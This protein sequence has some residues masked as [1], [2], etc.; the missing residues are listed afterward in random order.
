LNLNLILISLLTKIKKYHNKQSTHSNNATIIV[1]TTFTVALTY[2]SPLDIILNKQWQ[3]SSQTIET[4]IAK[5]NSIPIPLFHPHLNDESFHKIIFK[6]AIQIHLPR[7]LGV[8]NKAICKFSISFTAYSSISFDPLE[9]RTNR[10]HRND[11]LI[12]YSR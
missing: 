1:S 6:S 9:L 12:L 2:L 5:Y 4:L 8:A 7:R 10:D 3:Q 11:G